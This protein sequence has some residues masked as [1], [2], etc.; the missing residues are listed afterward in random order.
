MISSFDANGTAAPAR[1]F[2]PG[3]SR[4]H[5]DLA[6][7]IMANW[8]QPGAG[9]G[10]NLDQGSPILRSR[11]KGRRGA[12]R[13]GIVV[14][15]VSRRFNRVIGWGI[16]PAFPLTRKDRGPSAAGRCSVLSWETL[17]ARDDRRARRRTDLDPLEPLEGPPVDGLLLAGLFARRICRSPGQAGPVAT[18]GGH[19]DVTAILQ[20]TGA[21][22]ITSRSR[23]SRRARS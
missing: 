19:P 6:P 18:W 17:R 15:F 10:R 14:S 21:S 22:T 8:L 2:A 5:Q 9:G 16:R 20:N 3:A 1:L 11:M 12:S 7:R 4:L 23:W 13:S